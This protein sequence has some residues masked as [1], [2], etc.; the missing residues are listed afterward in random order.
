MCGRFYIDKDTLDEAERRV[1]KI[2]PAIAGAAY[3]G[4][5]RPTGSA[6][7]I[8]RDGNSLKLTGIRWGYPGAR[9]KGVIFNARAESVQSK[10]LFARGITAHRA[11]IPATLFYE[12]S[13]SDEKNAFERLDGNILYL[14]G[15]HD[16]ID[17]E[18]RFVILTTA[19]NPSMQPVHDRMPLILEEDQLGEWLQ[20]DLAA[21]K[22]LCQVP[23]LLK[24][25]CGQEQQ[26]FL[27]D[28]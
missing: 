14:A 12:W 1:H 6:P 27:P 11:V 2:D 7:V 16:I 13:R 17:N 22:L 4:D 23:A 15:F 3:S 24:R 28:F 25:S 20:D 5:I 21:G 9:S 19:A 18:D 10:A 26:T 8:V